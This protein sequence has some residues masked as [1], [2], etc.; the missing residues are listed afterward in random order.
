MFFRLVLASSIVIG[1]SACATRAPA[2]FSPADACS[3]TASTYDSRELQCRFPKVEFAR[4]FRLTA[5]FSGGHDDTVARLEPSIDDS[6]IDC[7]AGSKLHLSA[8]DGDVSLWCI[9]SVAE[10]A[11]EGGVFKTTIRWSHAEYVSH[12]VAVER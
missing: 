3:V 5:N 10:H 7:D 8:E 1:L 11:K 9:F 12:A 4:K 6:P 2:A